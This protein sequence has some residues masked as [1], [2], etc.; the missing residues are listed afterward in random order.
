[1]PIQN[2]IS[3]VGF[4]K[5][6]AKAS[7]AANPA[8]QIGVNSGQIA[9]LDITEEDF[10]TTWT[11]R[12]LEGHD[13]ISAAPGAAFEGLAMPKSIGLLLMLALGADSVTGAADPYTHEF[14][15]AVTLPYG[16]FFARKDTEYF[17]VGDARV[18]ELELA[19]ELTGALKVTVTVMGCTYTFNG[20]TAYTP[21]A[22]ERPVDG[23]LKGTGG[24][25]TVHGQTL[26]VKSGSIKISQSV[27]PVFGSNAVLPAD[28]FPGLTTVD[29]SLTL[30]PAN[31]QEFRRV[32]TG[33]TGGSSVAAVPFYGA[34]SLGFGVPG[35]ANRTLTIDIINQKSMVAFPDTNAQGG[36]TE[37]VVEGSVSNP[38]SGDAFTFTLLNDVATY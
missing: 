12:L 4:A 23:V 30:I 38:T 13:R 17:K 31:L 14:T 2:R 5:Q 37:L 8:Y 10:P 3:L 15:P 27:E 9:T 21:A 32:V 29:T 18:S 11:S 33:T 7:E 16:T 22:S 28:V 36:P 25:F 35:N 19:W 26:T 6:T 1:V 34:A 20:T 24:T